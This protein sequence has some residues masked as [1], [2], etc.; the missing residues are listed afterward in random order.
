M[1]LNRAKMVAGTPLSPRESK[2][3]PPH[4][5]QRDPTVCTD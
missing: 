3:V 5:M 2:V 1:V 4:Q